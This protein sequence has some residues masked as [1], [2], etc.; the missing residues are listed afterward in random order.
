MPKVPGVTRDLLQKQ[1]LELLEGI[2][3]PAKEWIGKGGDKVRRLVTKTGISPFK[4]NMI[5][6]MSQQKKTFTDAL[7]VFSNEAKFMMNANDQELMNFKNNLTTYTGAGGNPRGSGGE[8]LASMMKDLETSLKDLET[9]AKDLKLSTEEAKDFATKQMEEAL[10]TA[11]YGSPFKVPDKTSVGG[12]MYTE[13]NIRTALRE[14]LQSELKA[15][16]IKLNKTDTF[17][18]TEYS[19]MSEDDPIDVFRRIYGEDALDQVADIASVFEKG[20]SFK[21]YEQLLRENVD[22][23]VLTVKK[24][25]AGEY[26]LNVQAAEDIRTKVE[27]GEVEPLT[28][29]DEKFKK[30]MDDAIERANK[31]EPSGPTIDDDDIPFYAG[32]RVGLKYGTKKLFNFTKKQLKDAVNDIFPTGDRKYDA[33]M[34]SDAL[35]ENNPKKFKNRV[36]QDL[37]DSEYTEVYGIALN[38]LDAFN[39]EAR[40]LMKP[41][42]KGQIWKDEKGETEMIAMGWKDDEMKSLD[43]A[44]IKGKAMSDA[45]KRMGY[46]TSSGKQTLEF[47]ELVRQG[48]EGFSPE[49]REQVIR[50][51]YGDIVDTRLLNDLIGDTDSQH[52]SVVMGT[53]D[54]SMKM[55]EQGMGPDEI[56]QSIKDSLKRQPSATGGGVGSMFKGV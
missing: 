6:A 10:K 24:T 3:I 44:F 13:G 26:D 9:S 4:P 53:I 48:M 39:A 40:A 1:I 22:P 34:V 33:E 27:T 41:K 16:K 19:P 38:A 45:M 23:S 20:E 42:S 32:G 36:R 49:I 29:V 11:Q 54:E 14:F 18:V 43:Q 8:G 12:N 30:N 47:D 21:H 50:A 28:S 35:V 51:K 37:D 52:L 7:D 46:D 55:H 31:E 2:G 56:I 17:R 15:G 5:Q 25:G